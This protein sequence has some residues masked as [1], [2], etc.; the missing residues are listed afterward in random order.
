MFG[1]TSY[2]VA[3]QRKRKIMVSY[4]LFMPLSVVEMEVEHLKTRDIQRVKETKVCYSLSSIPSH[5]VK[6]TIA[7]FLAEVLYRIVR[8][9]EA[10]PKLFD[11]LTH[12]IRYLEILEQGIAN[13]HLVFLIYLT[14]Y[15]GVFPNAESYVPGV[16]FDMLN[17]IFTPQPPDHPH[18]LTKEESVIFSRL[19]RLTYENM[20]LHSFSRKERTTIIHYI[21]EYYRLHFSDLPEIKSLAVMQSLFD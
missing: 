11:Y 9:K 8:T 2:L 21:L 17:G 4:A 13:F 12:S 7:L 6:N 1:R 3:R 14:R 20:A 19:L 18:Y 16:Y 5:P 10:D 15:L